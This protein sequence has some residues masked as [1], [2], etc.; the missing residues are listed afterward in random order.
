MV[1]SGPT[2]N[3]HFGKAEE[4]VLLGEEFVAHHAGEGGGGVGEGEAL[5][6][7]LADGERRQLVAVVVVHDEEELLQVR[8]VLHGIWGEGRHTKVQVMRHS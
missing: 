5:D 7:L 8:G 2:G 4:R 6:E 1:E 3:E